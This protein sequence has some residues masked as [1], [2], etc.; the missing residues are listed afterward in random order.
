MQSLSSRAAKLAEASCVSFNGGSAQSVAETPSSTV[1]NQWGSFLF[2]RR[3]QFIWWTSGTWS[4]PFAT[5]AS[6]RWTTTPRSMCRGWRQSCLPSTTS[7]TSGCPPPTRSMWSSPSGCCSTSWWPLTTG[8]S[9]AASQG[10]RS[11]RPL[12]FVQ[13]NQSSDHWASSTYQLN[14]S[15]PSEKPYTSFKAIVIFWSISIFNVN[16]CF[17][18]F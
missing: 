3:S 7:S 12:F 9:A 5:T 1:T 6:T 8:R 2:A 17:E 14:W 18:C 11:I 16:F 15:N 10:A 4:K 13:Y